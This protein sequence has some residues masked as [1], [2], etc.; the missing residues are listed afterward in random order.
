[1]HS[2]SL[3]GSGGC[4]DQPGHP[5]GDRSA[6]D[7]DYDYDH[8]YYCFVWFLRLSVLSIVL[9]VFLPLHFYGDHDY[10]YNGDCDYDYDYDYDY[11]YHRYYDHGYH[12]DCYYYVLL[13]CILMTMMT[14]IIISIIIVAGVSLWG[15][16]SGS[17]MPSVTSSAPSRL[18]TCKWCERRSDAPNPLEF[19]LDQLDTK[20]VIP[21]RRPKGRECGI[22]PWTIE[23]DE[24]LRKAKTDGTLEQK[25]QDSEFNKGFHEKLDRWLAE[26]NRTCGGQIQRT[27]VTSKVVVAR[28]SD[29]TQA[30]K[31][32]GIL[33]N[34]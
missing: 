31:F 18:S 4:W 33:W 8:Y 22:C 14:I 9:L 19:H 21:W 13:F 2:L 10:D 20:P 23:A 3:A 25:M 6:Y 29:Y 11:A 26:K 24:E 7:Y 5:A 34:Y 15:S 30:R 1:M 32:L 27:L 28:A 12:D 16:G 17:V